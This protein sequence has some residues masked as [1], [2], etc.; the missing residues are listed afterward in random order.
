MSLSCPFCQLCLPA[1]E[2]ERHANNHLEEEELQRDM[3]LAHQLALAPTSPPI[4]VDQTVDL[5]DSIGDYSKV[6]SESSIAGKHRRGLDKFSLCRILNS[7]K[8]A[9]FHRIDAGLM[10]L[11]GI[12]LEMENNDTKSIIS[13]HVDHF[14]S[15][16]SEDSGWGCGWRNIQMLSSHL[17]MERQEAKE[18]LFGG[19]EFVPDIPSLQQWLELAWERGFDAPGAKSFNHKIYGSKEWIG[20][21]E[22]ATLFRSF[23]LRAKIIDFDGSIQSSGSSL[24]CLHPGKKAKIKEKKSFGPMD[25]FLLHAVAKDDMAQASNVSGCDKFTGTVQGGARTFADWVWNYFRSG[26]SDGSSHRVTISEKMPLYF[27]HSGHS[28]TI[29]GIQM[30]KGK[31]GFPDAYS[32]L[33]LD[34]SQSTIALEKSLIEKKGW[35]PLIKRG[36]H[37]L[38]KS[39]YQLCFVDTG[40]AHG[41]EFEDLKVLDS[42]LIKI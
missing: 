10:N 31:Q 4:L 40:I 11:L 13:G 18:V 7:Q 34:P 32:L 2:L 26:V 9:S 21:T 23:G 35:Q 25:K 16:E 20:A 33:V 19:S 36:V 3:N 1:D 8:R 28:R 22:C 42:T 38:K 29:V 6:S 39:Q 15:I 17:L 14:Q 41:V 12:C 24:L 27:Q 37:T 5:G 30:K